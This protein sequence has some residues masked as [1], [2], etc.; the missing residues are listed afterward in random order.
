MRR[1]HWAAT[2]A[3]AGLL[4]T[5]LLP[6]GTPG[7][8]PAGADTPETPQPPSA[9][10]DALS[11]DAHV[12]TTPITSS[13]A[14]PDATV[15]VDLD[16]PVGPANL[17]LN[18]MVWNTGDDLAPVAD[19]HPT[20]VRIDASLGSISPAPGEFHIDR[21]LAKIAEIRRIGAEPIVLLSYMPDWLGQ[22][23]ADA[24]N[25]GADPGRMAPYDLDAW[26]KLVHDVVKATATAPQPARIFEVWNEPDL[27]VF[28]LDTDQAFADMAVRTHRAV[29]D[30]EHETGLDLEVGGPALAIGGSV[31]SD[32]ATAYLDGIVSN[33]LPLDFWSWHRYANFPFL[34]PDG[35][36][37]H[38]DDTLY[39][40]LGKINPDATPL[41]YRDDVETTRS[42]LATVLAG[43]GLH[44]R[45]IIDEWN[46]SG[47]GLDLRHDTHVGAAFD[48]GIL[49]VMERAGLDGADFYRTASDADAGDWGIVANDGTRKPAWWLMRA[50]T[51]MTGERLAVTDDAESGLFARATTDRDGCTQVLVSN[52]LASGGTARTVRLDLHGDGTTACKADMSSLDP[53]SATLETSRPVRFAADGTVTLDIPAQSMVLLRGNCVTQPA[54]DATPDIAP[55]AEPVAA[56]PS[57]TG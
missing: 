2:V 15:D 40:S 50:W 18:G 52:F 34:G 55:S 26:Q 48:A 27:D 10:C 37:G 49:T 53:D 33:G 19:L 16:K 24:R 20:T 41:G 12:D 43:T 8:D 46:V 30:V 17:A 51:A 5:T 1:T 14:Q 31:T 7:P 54:S 25:P 42:H 9:V 23:S 3:A 29:V 44:P 36:E 56:K 11:P 13:T 21:L 57:F 22:P 32:L 39:A 38:V 47:G 4:A 6:I 28:W 35:N 45:L